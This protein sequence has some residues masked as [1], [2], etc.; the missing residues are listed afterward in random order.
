MMVNDKKEKI[1]IIENDA[2]VLYGLQA[3]LSMEGFAVEIN[4]GT[5]EIEHVLNLIRI[6]KPDYIV[7]NLIL[8]NI[9]GAAFLKALKSGDGIKQSC[10][11]AFTNLNEKDDRKWISI[12]GADSYFIKNEFA[13]D[14]FVEKLKKIIE[15]RK[16][17][18][19]N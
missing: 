16:K 15:N 7:L 9:D 13:V 8:P 19:K 18:G 4:D 3:K 12:L 2:N 14:S 1:Y 17:I 11:F 10:I 6:S 5:D